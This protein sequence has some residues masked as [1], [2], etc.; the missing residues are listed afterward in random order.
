MASCLTPFS[1]VPPHPSLQIS[2]AELQQVLAQH[3]NRLVV[4]HFSSGGCPYSAAFRPWLAQ[5]AQRFPTA[6][7]LHITTDSTAATT[8]GACPA[9]AAET[10]VAAAAAGEGESLPASGM[11]AAVHIGSLPCTL[12]L[13]GGQVIERL[14]L[15][16]CSAASCSDIAA[17]QP[18]DEAAGAAR[19][20][21]A[22]LLGAAMRVRL[23][24]ADCAAADFA[25]AAG[26][27]PA[28]VFA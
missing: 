12:L 27:A 17:W 26:A 25:A 5:A 18:A 11:L 22:A 23:L 6:L 10:A 28:M 15:G 2:A 16:G 8:C 3:P 19:E 20:L 21:H 1:S 7:F 9:P 24:H 13:H 14:E 4:A